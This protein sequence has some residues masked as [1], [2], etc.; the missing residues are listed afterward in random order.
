MFEMPNNI[1]IGVNKV[2]SFMSLTNYCKM[3]R[4]A[5]ISKYIFRLWNTLIPN[6]HFNQQGEIR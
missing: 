5:E 6:D 1:L 3:M 4:Y 2:F